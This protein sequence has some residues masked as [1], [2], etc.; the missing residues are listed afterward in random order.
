MQVYDVFLFDRP[1][2]TAKVTRT[3]L[4]Y[5]ITCKCHIC[6]SVYKLYADSEKGTVLIGV[7]YP[8]DGWYEINKRISVKSLGM[9]IH[10]FRVNPLNEEQDSFYE[11]SEDQP[12]PHLPQ[13]EKACL[14]I[15]N[16]RLGIRF[17]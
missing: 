9:D 3:G 7:F 5:N 16:G 12:F 13:I 4:Y 1:I 14:V 10:T 2:G 17:R 11:I 6:E 15:K 8:N